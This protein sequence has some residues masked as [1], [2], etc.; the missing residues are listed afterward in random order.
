MALLDQTWFWLVVVLLEIILAFWLARRLFGLPKSKN[1]NRHRC[2]EDFEWQEIADLGE[3]AGV[4]FELGRCTNCG[5]FILS[6]FYVSSTTYN[7]ISKQRAEAFLA[8]QGKA[9]LKK[10]LKRWIS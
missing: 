6:V 8:L 7:V 9:E 5:A 10:A 1:T 3:A 2:C 4:D